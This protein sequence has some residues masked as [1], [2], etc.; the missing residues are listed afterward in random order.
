MTARSRPGSAARSHA[1]R[2]RAVCAAARHPPSGQ[3]H[4]VERGRRRVGE[5][6]LQHQPGPAAPGGQDARQVRGQ[7]GTEHPAG[8]LEVAQHQR[9]QPGPELGALRGED[10]DRGPGLALRPGQHPV[11]RGLSGPHARP[12]QPVPDRGQRPADGVQGAFVPRVLAGQQAALGVV[13]DERHPVRG[14]ERMP[15]LLPDPGPFRQAEQPGHV[16]PDARAGQRGLVP[17]EPRPGH[18]RALG[19][20][21]SAPLHHPGL[22]PLQE[23]DGGEPRVEQPGAQL[24]EP[25]RRPVDVVG[26]GRR[27]AGEEGELLVRRQPALAHQGRRRDLQVDPAEQRPVQL[28]LLRRHQVR[29]GRGEPDDPRRVELPDHRLQQ[30]APQLEQVVALVEDQRPRAAVAE[31]GDQLAPVRMQ[32]RQHPVAV[33]PPDPPGAVHGH[34]RAIVSRIAVPGRPQRAQGLVGQHGE[35][36]R[37]LP[38]GRGGHLGRGE[39]SL[40]LRHPLGLDGRVGAEHH[41]GPAKPPRR[42]QP[43]QRLPAAGRH[44]Q[45]RRLVPMRPVQG[46]ERASL[47]RPQRAGQADAPEHIGQLA[48]GRPQPCLP[49]RR[50]IVTTGRRR[51]HPA[52]YRPRVLVPRGATRSGRVARGC[53]GSWFCP[54]SRRWWCRRG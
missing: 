19:G 20:S 43:D 52:L 35:R 3:Q 27:R 30:A 13:A 28:R 5:Q 23:R 24:G 7:L 26:L 50:R 14:G 33:Q 45:V 22:Q 40:P 39:R 18:L 31:P 8:V 29:R 1:I 42:L 6:G 4:R 48:G 10:L 9:P 44:H 32:Q 34:R 53:G 46:G 54:C 21:G 12:G 51:H 36:G 37:Q 17:L 47:V 16:Q 15:V 38:A 2:R 41:R 49:K 25:Q 11:D